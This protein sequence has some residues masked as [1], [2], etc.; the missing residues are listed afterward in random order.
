ML[1]L[2]KQNKTMTKQ[3]RELLVGILLGDAHIRK[4]GTQKAYFTFE[5][6]AQKVDYFNH[7]FNTFKSENLV[8]DMPK[9][10]Q[11]SDIRYNGKINSSW[12]FKSNTVEELRPLA[13]LFLDENGGKRVPT[14]ISDLLTPRSLAF[15]IMDDGQQVKTGGVTLCTDS[16][17]HEEI[18]MLR[19]V[20]ASKFDLK[21]TI[22][23]KK[24]VS[25]VYERIYIGKNS[26][27]ES[28]KPSL[29]DHMQESMLYK[30]NMGPKPD[31]NTPTETLNT[32]TPSSTGALTP[33]IISDEAIEKIVEESNLPVVG[34]DSVNELLESISDINSNIGDLL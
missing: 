23:L 21:T 27:F 11:R 33:S 24:G 30:I 34:L 17:K 2:K 12:H 16:F 29:A 13:D 31:T 9:F 5:Q 32:P 8:K 6:S 19:D 10:Y 25:N 26:V 18:E 14:N 7:V 28:F 20:L 4:V 3:L 22:H 1:D 15:W